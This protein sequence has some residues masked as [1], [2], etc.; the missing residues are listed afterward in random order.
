MSNETYQILNTHNDVGD[1]TSILRFRGIQW[2]LTIPEIVQGI[3]IFP[4]IKFRYLEIV[5]GIH[6]QHLRRSDTAQNEPRWLSSCK[7]LREGTQSQVDMNDVNCSPSNIA[8]WVP[9]I[10]FFSGWLLLFI[11]RFLRLTVIMAVSL[12]HWGYVGRR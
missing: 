11:I 5:I 3:F 7:N 9:L 6:V 12:I 4:S 8:H 10:S 1:N 2:F